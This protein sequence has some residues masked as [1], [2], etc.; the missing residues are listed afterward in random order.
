MLG[1]HVAELCRQGPTVWAG[2][3][4]TGR[5]LRCAVSQADVQAARAPHRLGAIAEAVEQHGQD[6][7][8]V[9]LKQ[10]AQLLTQALK[11]QQRA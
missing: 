10:P 6:L 11:R 4:G 1:R 9:R 5:G 8:D 7:D 2:A 3:C